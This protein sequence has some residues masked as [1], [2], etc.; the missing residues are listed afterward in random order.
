[1]S[2]ETGT[3]KVT[4]LSPKAVEAAGGSVAVSA[5]ETGAKVEMPAAILFQ[6]AEL[7]E[8]TGASGPVLLSLTSMSDETAE[9]FADRQ[10]EG[11]LA[12]TLQSQPLSINL[13]GA[14]GSN[15]KIGEMQTPMEIVLKVKSPNATCAYW[16][17]DESRWSSKGLTALSNTAGQLTCLTTHLSI[18]TGVLQ[19][20]VE[21][22]A[23]VISCS[24]WDLMSEK[25]LQ[26]L[27]GSCRKWMGSLPSISTFVF[28]ALFLAIQCRVAY[29][30][31]RDKQMAL[32]S[33][34]D[35]PPRRVR[36][37]RACCR[38][39]LVQLKEWCCWCTGICFGV[40][41][42][43]QHITD[44]IPN[45]PQPS[46]NRCIRSLHA[47]RCR[48]ALLTNEK[49]EVEDSVPR[50]VPRTQVRRSRVSRLM[51]SLVQTVNQLAT[52][53]RDLNA[54]WEVHLHGA[55]AVESILQRGWCSRV[56]L[57]A[58]SMRSS[59]QA[60]QQGPDDDP[61]CRQEL[62]FLEGLVQRCIVG[63]LASFLGD[64]IISTLF[65]V[66]VRSPS[67]K[68]QW[69]EAAKSWKLAWWRCRSCVFWLL[70]LVYT[71]TCLAYIM[72]FLASAHLE[73]AHN[74]YQSTGMSLLQDMVL[75]PLGMALVLGTIATCALRSQRI[76]TSIEQKWYHQP[77]DGE[78]K[79]AQRGCQISSAS[80]ASDQADH[81]VLDVGHRCWSLFSHPCHA[82]GMDR[83]FTA[84]STCSARSTCEAKY[85]MYVIP[86]RKLMQMSKFLVHREMLEKGFLEEFTPRTKGKVIVVSHEWLSYVHPDPNQEHFFTLKRVLDRLGNG[87]VNRVEDYWLH[88]V[89]FRSVG[90]T[91]KEWKNDFDN[92]YIWIDY[93]CIPQIEVDANPETIH[94]SS[95]AVQSIA[96]YV[97]RSSLLLVLAPVCIHAETGRSCNFA[98]WRRRGWC[99]MEMMTAILSSNK[100]R[101]MVCT[102]AEATPFLMH[103]FEAP[104][105]PVGDG[106]FSCCALGHKLGGAT[107]TCDKKRLR[108]VLEE[109][110]QAKVGTLKADG[111]VVERLWYASMQQH[112]LRNLP[113]KEVFSLQADQAQSSHYFPE[114]EEDVEKLHNFLQRRLSTGRQGADA[115]RRTLG[116]TNFDDQRCRSTGCTLMMCAAIADSPPAIRELAAKDKNNTVNIGLRK[117]YY[118]L[119]FMWKGVRPLGAA[120]AFSSWETVAALLDCGADPKLKCSNG[121]DSLFFAC[122]IGNLT[123]IQGW[124]RRFPNWDMERRIPIMGMNI[125]CAATC[126]GTNKALRLWLGVLVLG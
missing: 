4:A 83:Q 77:E 59:S 110:L 57:L 107:L 69:T 23:A 123:N 55:S 84:C 42:I 56:C 49:F 39:C 9:S 46:V 81:L 108:G 114:G 79:V 102:G 111:L 25:G 65:L 71:I 122:C 106:D 38:Y 45:A 82:A 1:M 11:E 36:P 13:R 80:S 18:F 100:V 98:S 93:C 67:E 116:W 113:E 51:Q 26:K 75:L 28:I 66:Q 104:R 27:M 3:L 8:K 19:I 124:F 21:R 97:E 115:L 48:V 90:I 112:F 41:K 91:A 101:I 53:V 68:K 86:V 6:A 63:C 22:A 50:Q 64:C 10:V 89:M 44:A 62:G 61:G 78:R 109:M 17:E 15:L 96:A 32:P 5:G 35:L 118:H 92:M 16:D 73:D 54:R 30:D 14:D 95:L 120:M 20:I 125:F 47:H 2:T 85:P 12:T 52:A 74:W 126:S 33:D 58:L 72:M 31:R 103:P 119:A 94:Q 121:M 105:L 29:V 37:T 24:R 7:F 70:W 40:E 43:L 87:E 88:S 76:R 99:R 34:E 117:Q 60:P